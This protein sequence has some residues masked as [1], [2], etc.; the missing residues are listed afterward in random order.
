MTMT[1]TMTVTMTMTMAMTMT[2]G[3][4]RGRGRGRSRNLS[5]AG[6]GAENFKNGRLRQP[7][8][9]SDVSCV[10]TSCYFSNS[11]HITVFLY[12]IPRV[13][14]ISRHVLCINYFKSL[15]FALLKFLL[16]KSW[17]ARAKKNCWTDK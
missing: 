12:L 7:C 13:I 14:A 17:H 16:H 10:T 8:Y 11:A 2:R 9:F 1:M 5:R 4:G 15:F 6:A 3:R